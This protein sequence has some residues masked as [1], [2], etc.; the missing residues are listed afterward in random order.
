MKRRMFVG[1]IMAAIGSLFGVRAKGG[2]APLVTTVPSIPDRIIEAD[3]VKCF[4]GGFPIQ[5][6][7]LTLTEM[8]ATRASRIGDWIMFW[9]KIILTNPRDAIWCP[10][11]AKFTDGNLS[12]WTT[13]PPPCFNGGRPYSGHV[14][15]RQPD[16]VA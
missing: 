8:N 15:L 16:Q 1:G 3:G 11:F 7:G 12:H 9:N 14:V 5:Q 2:V 10:V 4:I 13:E 6:G